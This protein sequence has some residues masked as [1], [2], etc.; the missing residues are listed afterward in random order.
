MPQLFRFTAIGSFHCIPNQFFKATLQLRGSHVVL[1]T[2]N[3][4]VR[5]SLLNSAYSAFFQV[6]IYYKSER[7]FFAIVNSRLLL[8][9]SDT[10][11]VSFVWTST[12][13]E[14]NA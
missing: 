5:T 1:T 14:W 9:M 7:G 8:H 2:C 12:K 6:E 13:N 4:E 11:V 3:V 10:H